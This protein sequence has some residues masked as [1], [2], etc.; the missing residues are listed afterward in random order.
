VLTFLNALVS[1]FSREFF[2]SAPLVFILWAA[3]AAGLLFWGRGPFCGWLCAF[4]TLQEFVSLA[5]K[6]LGI[7]QITVPWALHERLWPIKYIIFLG[8]FGLSL[9]RAE[10]LAE[11]SPSRPRSS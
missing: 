6:R 2:L 3:V 10:V 1:G 5:A 4:G 9:A 7:P 11:S 8:L